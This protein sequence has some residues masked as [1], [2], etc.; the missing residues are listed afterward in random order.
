MPN[1]RKDMLTIQQLVQLKSRGHSHKSIKVSLGISR[2]TV[3]EYVRLLEASGFSWEQLKEMD[4]VELFPLHGKG[5]KTT[6]H[7]QE[8]VMEGIQQ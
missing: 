6:W 4:V 2:T 8:V 1:K 3:I 5:V 7:Y